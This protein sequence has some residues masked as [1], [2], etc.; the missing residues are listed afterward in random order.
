MKFGVGV[1]AM[2]DA[3]L[4]PIIGSGV[5]VIGT[6]PVL[7]QSVVSD[8]AG[9]V[10]TSGSVRFVGV[11]VVG[12][13]AVVEGLRVVRVVVA[14]PVARVP[15][16]AGE[17]SFRIVPIGIVI[18]E[19]VGVLEVARVVGRAPPILAQVVASR[20]IGVVESVV[21]RGTDEGTDR[22]WNRV[23]SPHSHLGE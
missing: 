12:S 11:P 16:V 22:I 15:E 21:E 4:S 10:E 14:T 8:E 2:I 20:R 3:E 19:G 18:A 7:V 5:G 1:E 13:V 23:S 9:V 6:Q 17:W